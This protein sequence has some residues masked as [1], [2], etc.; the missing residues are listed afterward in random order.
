MKNGYSERRISKKLKLC[1][2]GI[3]QVIVKFRNLG[4]IQDLHKSGRSKVTSQ[5]DEHMIKWMVVCSPT[6]LGKKIGLML[7]LKSTSIVT[8]RTTKFSCLNW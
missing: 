3:H 5:R 8:A 2:K 4:S 6:S 1:Q 7:L